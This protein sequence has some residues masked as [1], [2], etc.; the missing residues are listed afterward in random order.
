MSHKQQIL[1]LRQSG[2]TYDEICTILNCSKGTVAYHCGKDQ[3]TKHHIRQNK[4][5]NKLHPYTSKLNNFIFRN[6]QSKY[7]FRQQQSNKRLIL[8][9]IYRFQKLSGDKSMTLFTIEDIINKF[10]EKPKCYLTGKEINIYQP[11]TYNFDHI[12][13]A[14]RGGDNSLDN[15]GICTKEANQAKH[16]MTPDEF[17]NFCRKVVNYHDS[18]N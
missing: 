2:K 5:R 13:P 3:K 15:L 10:G 16:N 4:R 12:I 17:I 8:A 18:K 14:S 9:K 11:R 7:S 1:E 6:Y